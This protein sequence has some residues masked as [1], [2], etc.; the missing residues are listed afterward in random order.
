MRR[1]AQYNYAMES[2]PGTVTGTGAHNG[3]TPFS[4]QVGMTSQLREYDALRE[5]WA[6]EWGLP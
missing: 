2:D 6:W 1:L 4:S 5:I 3:R